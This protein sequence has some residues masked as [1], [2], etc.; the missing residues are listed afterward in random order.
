MIVYIVVWTWDSGG[1]FSFDLDAVLSCDTYFF[2]SSLFQYS[3][4]LI[5]FQRET[6]AGCVCFTTVL[7]L[8]DRNYHDNQICDLCTN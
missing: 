5:F 3:Y 6:Y 2:F 7:E 8:S 4:Q 1:F